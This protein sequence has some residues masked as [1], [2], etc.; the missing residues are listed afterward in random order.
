[1][2]FRLNEAASDFLTITSLPQFRPVPRELVEELG[3]EWRDTVGDIS[4][5]WQTPTNIVVNGPFVPSVE[6]F[7]DDELVLIRNAIWPL[8][9]RGNIDSINIQ[10]Q[11][12]EM[13]MF[14]LWQER[15]LDVSLLP[16]EQR[17]DF[18][19]SSPDKAHL[20]TNQTV[21]YV[22]FNFDSPVFQEPE[23]RRAFSAAID[24]SSL[25]DTMFEGRG[26]SL[27]HF[28]PPGVFGSPPENE[29]GIGYSPDF[30][31]QQMDKSSIRSCKLLPPV[32]ML[33]STADLSLLQA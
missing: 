20:F 23:V 16:A 7:T 5:G 12:D 33:V 32:T 15:G 22:G 29:I 28:T 25:I 8:P 21:F 26:L 10:L 6:P 2:Q 17:E 27:R 14:N 30:A 4:N 1:V 13:E 11:L 31:L 24:R 3:D 18:L 19:E 9:P